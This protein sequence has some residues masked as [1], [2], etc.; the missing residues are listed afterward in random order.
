MALIEFDPKTATREQLE[1]AARELAAQD[2]EKSARE[3]AEREATRKAAADAAWDRATAGIRRDHPEAAG[4]TDD[5]L[6]NI[7]FAVRDYYEN[8]G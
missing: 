5:V 1:A 6:W 2:R 4:L 8:W 3:S 7:F